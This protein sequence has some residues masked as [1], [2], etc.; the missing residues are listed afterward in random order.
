M[1]LEGRADFGEGPSS[2]GWPVSTPPIST[3]NS[4]CNYWIV[5]AIEAPSPG[6]PSTA[7]HEHHR[8]PIAT[9]RR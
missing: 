7:N 2:I 9:Y 1:V 6:F 4:G 5:I 8:R 3:Q